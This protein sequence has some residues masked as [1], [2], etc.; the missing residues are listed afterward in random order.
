MLWLLNWSSLLLAVNAMLVSQAQLIGLLGNARI[1]RLNL[2]FPFGPFCFG[3]ILGLVV[4]FCI[5]LDV[6]EYQ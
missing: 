2:A 6:L 3:R 4:H 5:V 1:N